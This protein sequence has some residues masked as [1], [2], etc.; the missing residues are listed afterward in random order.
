V[1]DLGLT[2]AAWLKTIHKPAALSYRI[3]RVLEDL[4]RRFA[5]TRE[6]ATFHGPANTLSWPDPDNTFSGIDPI[7]ATRNTDEEGRLWLRITGSSPTATV[8][9][10]SATGASGLV[11]E[12]TGNVSDGGIATLTEQNSSGLTATLQ[13]PSTIATIAA[14]TAYFKVLI[15]YQKELD[16]LWDGTG[17]DDQH[18]KSDAKAMLDALASGLESLITGPVATFEN[19]LMINGG[20]EN[21]KPQVRGNLK[22]VASDLFSETETPNGSNVT[23]PI[24]GLYVDY[25]RAMAAETTGSTQDIAQRTVARA[26]ATFESTNVGAGAVASGT[27]EQRCPAADWTARCISGLGNGGG[28]SEEFEVTLSVTAEDREVTYSGWFV[29][30]TFELPEGGGEVTITRTYSKN[31]TDA[32][33]V[34]VGT[35]ATF[36]SIVGATEDNTDSG[37]LYGKLVSNASNWDVEFYSDSGRVTTLVAKVVNVATSATNVEATE[38]N[39]SGLT[40]IIFDVGSAPTNGGTFEIDLQ[41]FFIGDTDSDADSFT[42]ATTETSSGVYAKALAEIDGRQLNGTTIGAEQVTDGPVILT[43]TFPDRVAVDI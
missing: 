1:P 24:S 41:F 39:S 11:A 2:D 19:R 13:M 33:N 36:D 37:T 10:Y 9:L 31:G 8:S 32:T 21:E 20:E 12:A 30:A 29:E 28:G 16:L 15:D 23:R 34:Q 22:S 26:A 38:Q 14:D 35:A 4:R 5:R 18:S 25:S 40:S 27:A 7:S 17:G 42:F 6:Q 43:N 3:K